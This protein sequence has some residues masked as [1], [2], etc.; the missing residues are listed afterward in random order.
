MSRK[1][2]LVIG[3]S[4]NT[5]RYANRAAKMLLQQGH[6]IELVGLREGRIGDE[7]I[8]TGTPHLADIDTVTM[9]VGPQNQPGYYDYIKGLRPKRVIFNPG[10]ENPDFARQLLSNGIEPVNACTLVMLSVG[11]Y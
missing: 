7:L 9:Y 2:T 3:A 6:P 1:K 11:T 10:A 5:T 8:Q 4:E